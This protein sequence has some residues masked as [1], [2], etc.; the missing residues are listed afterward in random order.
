M[1]WWPLTLRGSGALVLAVV[2]FVVAG[3]T[4]V[5]ELMFFGVLMLALLTGSLV[6]LWTF[7]VPTARPRRLAPEVGTVGM[8]TRVSIV[9]TAPRRLLGHSSRWRDEL[10]ATV[11]GTASG[12]VSWPASGT[13]ETTIE[14]TVTATARGLHSLGPLRIWNVDP[15]GVARRAVKVLPP[16]SMRAAPEEVE[17]A[18]VRD[19]TATSGDALHTTITQRGHGVDNLLARQYQPGDSMRRIHWRASAHH[20][21]LMVRQEENESA[22]DATVV[23]D[24]DPLRWGPGA[25]TKPGA[26]PA[27]E[28]AVATCV[29]AV[30]Q[31]SR[32]GYTVSVLDSTGT[33]LHDAISPG[34]RILLD[35]FAADSATLLADSRP[36]L[37][38][39]PRVFAT[40]SAGPVVIITGW[41]SEADVDTLAP[42]GAHTTLPILLATGA[43]GEAF[44]RAAELGWRCAA[45]RIGP[46]MPAWWDS[47]AAEPVPVRGGAA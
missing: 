27:F 37:H 42:L 38:E 31:L 44:D 10:P 47:A 2:A 41:L 34:E 20:D 36:G 22:P 13:G 43:R 40:S 23:L 1:R 15:F 11:T 5:V 6:S 25:D 3:E 33:V 18:A 14:Y 12:E 8:P 28:A 29:S 46:Q 39:I 32:D 19:V 17:V 30:S 9:L 7:G 35:V 16:V 26:D 4:G 45:I 21:G 24:R